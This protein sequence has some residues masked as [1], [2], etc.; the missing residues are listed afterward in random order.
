[1]TTPTKTIVLNSA[2]AI[3]YHTLVVCYHAHC[4]IA[5][6]ACLLIRVGGIVISCDSKVINVRKGWTWD[7][8]RSGG[9]EKW[10]KK[11]GNGERYLSTWTVWDIVSY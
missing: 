9:W 6:L 1:M 10:N 3:V 2:H 7:G 11:W 5:Y 4:S 8:K